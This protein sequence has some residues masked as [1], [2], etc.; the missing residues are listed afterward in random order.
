MVIL[1]ANQSTIFAGPLVGLSIALF[2]LTWFQNPMDAYGSSGYHAHAGPV[3]PPSTA[4]K[5]ATHGLYRTP[6]IYQFKPPE[7]YRDLAPAV[8]LLVQRVDRQHS[9]YYL[10]PFIS[11][12]QT[13][14][15]VIVD[16]VD[17]RF[18]EAAK[19][20]TPSIY[21]KISATRAVDI[22]ENHLWSKQRRPPGLRSTPSLV[23]QPCRQSQ[24]PYEPLWYFKADS[25]EW[26]VDQAGQVYPRLEEVR[27]K[28]GSA[29]K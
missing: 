2:T 1:N 7:A 17:G 29:D 12:G 25:T 26:Y 3:L 19:L 10:V 20:S 9:F 11:H 8:A 16:A 22:L 15:V 18:K 28:G 21:P 6:W 27:L 14:L 13:V 24:S 23:W 4:R 5:M